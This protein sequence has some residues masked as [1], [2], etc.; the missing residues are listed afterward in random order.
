VAHHWL[1][2]RPLGGGGCVLRLF[3]QVS[4]QA[5]KHE[6][7]TA[8]GFNPQGLQLT[9]TVTRPTLDAE[10]KKLRTIHHAS[11]LGKPCKP[12]GTCL[13]ETTT[14]QGPG[15]CQWHG[16]K[17]C[18][19]KSHYTLPCLCRVCFQVQVLPQHDHMRCFTARWLLL[20]GSQQQLWNTQLV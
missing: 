11:W 17:D 4:D 20:Q 10:S 5:G 3:S 18:R 16:L 6:C 19:L 8:S 14:T 1:P 12:P 15:L 7:C 2:C 9:A 13:H